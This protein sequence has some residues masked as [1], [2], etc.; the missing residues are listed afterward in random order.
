MAFFPLAAQ[1]RAIAVNDRAP[2]PLERGDND[3]V[4]ASLVSAAVKSTFP[5]LPWVE[6]HFCTA[7]GFLA[8]LRLGRTEGAVRQQP[9]NAAASDMYAY[10]DGSSSHCR[11]RVSSFRGLP[12]RA[13]ALRRAARRAAQ[14]STNATCALDDVLRDETAVIA[15]A[16]PARGVGP[17]SL[18]SPGAYPDQL[19]NRRTPSR[20]QPSS[21]V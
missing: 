3:P 15:S 10:R 17:V 6:P 21:P 13:S 8:S 4:T 2:A 12:Q 1:D 14:G 7:F 20:G 19:K 18:L 16:P 5:R 9:R 11:S